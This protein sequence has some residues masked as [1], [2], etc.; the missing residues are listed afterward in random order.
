[1]QWQRDRE[2][3][4]AGR[5]FCRNNC[6][7][8][9]DP[10]RKMSLV[11]TYPTGEF[12]WGEVD[13]DE[14]HPGELWYEKVVNYDLTVETVGGVQYFAHDFKALFVIRNAAAEGDTLWRIIRWDDDV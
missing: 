14:Q 1:V 8:V 9:D 5:M 6:P 2:K 12:K 4:S 10:I 11:L 3:R 7:D 13:P